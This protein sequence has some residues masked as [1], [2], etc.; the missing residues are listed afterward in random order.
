MTDMKY[1]T[2]SSFIGS[3]LLTFYSRVFLPGFTTGFLF[4][5]GLEDLGWY[6]DTVFFFTDDNML[7]Y[8]MK[9]DQK[10]LLTSVIK[11]R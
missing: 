7:L 9:Y 2:R 1:L 3:A 5:L 4:R 10:Q 11:T 6:L 8:H